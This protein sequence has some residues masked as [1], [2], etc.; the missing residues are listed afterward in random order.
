[1]QITYVAKNVFIHFIDTYY[2]I[3]WEQEEGLYDVIPAK[4]IVLLIIAT[5]F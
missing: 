3:K 5:T 1:M 4:D 2:L